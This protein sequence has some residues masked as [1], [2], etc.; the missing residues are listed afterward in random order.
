MKMCLACLLAVLLK[1]VFMELL[2]LIR[3]VNTHLTAYDIGFHCVASGAFRLRSK[4]VHADHVRAAI[5]NN[6]HCFGVC[7]MCSYQGF[8]LF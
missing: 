8:V 3:V 6:A 5:E 7:R 4:E 2:N 1:P